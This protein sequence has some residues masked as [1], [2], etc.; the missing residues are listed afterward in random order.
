MECR[1]F[2]LTAC[3]VLV[4]FQ[5]MVAL[6]TTNVVGS[7]ILGNQLSNESVEKWQAMI[8]TALNTTVS[9][10]MGMDTIY[11][12]TE[13][14]QAFTYKL[15]VGVRFDL[16]CLVILLCTEPLYYGRNSRHAILQ[17]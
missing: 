6:S 4:G 16:L 7:A 3:Y 14:D 5:E 8:L 2:S 17:N 9:E 1:I 13:A 11:N 15:L 12:N 10:S